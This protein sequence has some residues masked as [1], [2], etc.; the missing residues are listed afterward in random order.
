M[1]IREITDWCLDRV[2][3]T[4]LFE[5]AANRADAIK[6]VRSLAYQIDMHLIYLYMYPESRDRAHWIAE[7]N[8]WFADIDDIWLKP[9]N[10]KLKKTDYF[11][12]LFEERLGDYEEEITKKIAKATKDKGR[13]QQPIDWRL[14]KEWLRQVLDRV[15]EDLSASPDVTG[16]LGS[17]EDIT[18][19]L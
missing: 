5:M 10:R 4:T 11:K 8:G 2:A 18:N 6:H 9:D 15:C 1:K 12:L 7:L 14:L 13:P 17:F 19:Y 3:R 16:V